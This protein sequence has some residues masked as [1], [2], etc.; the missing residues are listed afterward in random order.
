MESA[1]YRPIHCQNNQ[2]PLGIA[3]QAAPIL[4]WVGIA[5]IVIDQNYQRPIT[6]AGLRTIQTIARNFCWSCFTPVLLAPIDGGKFAVIDGQHRVSAALLCGITSVPA[7]VVP[8]TAAEQASAFVRVNTVQTSMSTIS[9][10]RAS[11]MAGEPWAVLAE[12]AVSAAG[13]KLLSVQPSHKSKK[14]GDIMCIGLIKNLVLAGHAQS[15]TVTLSAMRAIETSAA[16]SI[17]LYSTWVLTPL[18]TAV[19]EFPE[20]NADTLAAILR[21]K[22]PFQIIAKAE[23]AAESARVP[24]APAIRQAFVTLIKAHVLA[25]TATHPDPDRQPFLAQVS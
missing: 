18:M 24:K 9:K 14:C 2:E 12:R 5:H 21:S 15:V 22:S 10:Y 19:A 13:C 20:L 25:Q 4:S 23:T 1:R 6:P 11:L 16:S 3:D 17:L 7:M 8:I